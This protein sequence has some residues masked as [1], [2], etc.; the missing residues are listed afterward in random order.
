MYIFNTVVTAFSRLSSNC[1]SLVGMTHVVAEK[2]VIMD[3][4]TT[5][6]RNCKTLSISRN[7]ALILIFIFICCIVAT[8]L[9]VYHFASCSAVA[10]TKSEIP[11]VVVHDTPSGPTNLVCVNAIT[12]ATTITTETTTIPAKSDETKT[13]PLNLRLQ[14]SVLPHSYRLKL[15][16]F[17]YE[18]NFTFHGE[19]T[20]LVNVTESVS[21]ITLHAAE[22]DIDKDSVKVYENVEGFR[23]IPI[24]ELLNNSKS[25][26]FTINLGEHLQPIK[27]YNI[28]IRFKGILNDLLEGFYRSFY[29]ENNQTK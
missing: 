1:F 23:D 12:E 15:I 29:V 18:G 28:Y 16:P 11:H 21:S 7:F 22:L 26:F 8:G 14:K 13:A 19:V 3:A 5:T 6:F 25:E 10:A 4:G 24:V 20:I 2:L 27:Q 17:I 9:L